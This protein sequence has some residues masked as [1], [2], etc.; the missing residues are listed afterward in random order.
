LGIDR[1]SGAPRNVKFKIVKRLSTVN[2]ISDAYKRA[3]AKEF[4]TKKC[5]IR[6]RVE[7]V[8]HI[9][10]NKFVWKRV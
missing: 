1:K 4:E 7:H 3:V 2:K 10:K 6:A 9:I 5:G 8:F